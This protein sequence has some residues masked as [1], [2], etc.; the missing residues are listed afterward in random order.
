L[1]LVSDGDGVCGAHS[2][3]PEL[4]PNKR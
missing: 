1:P 2:V 3:L 4:I